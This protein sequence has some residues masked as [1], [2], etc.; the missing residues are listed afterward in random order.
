MFLKPVSQ[1][2]FW[3]DKT[4]ANWMYGQELSCCNRMFR[5]GFF[6]CLY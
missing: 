2:L 6:D 1:A 5:Y 3:G 4:C